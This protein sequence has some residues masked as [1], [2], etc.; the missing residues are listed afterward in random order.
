MSN[1]FLKPCWRCA[2]TQVVFERRH[3]HYANE[4]AVI[5]CLT[6]KNQLIGREEQIVPQWNRRIIED[7]LLLRIKQL[8]EALAR[9]DHAIESHRIRTRNAIDIL[10]EATQ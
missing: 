4:Y 8:R 3:E 9:R 10:T 1:P 5:N 6:C 7:I 2:S